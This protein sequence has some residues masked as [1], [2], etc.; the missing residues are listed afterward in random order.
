MKI[1]LRLAENNLFS[2]NVVVVNVKLFKNINNALHFG[3]L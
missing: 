3:H 2:E 1:L